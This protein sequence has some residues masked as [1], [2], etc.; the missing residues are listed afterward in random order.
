M[1]G[2]LFGISLPKVSVPNIGVPTITTDIII[3]FVLVMVLL[4][5][6]LLGHNK[7]K[8]L[9]LSVFVGLVMVLTFADGAFSMLQKANWT[10]GGKISLPVVKIVLFVLPVIA[11]EFARKEGRRG[12]KNITM[13]IILCLLT[14]AL[15]VSSV[16][17]FLDAAAL[18]DI[19][20]KSILADWIY[21]LRMVWLGAVPLVVVAE[22]LTGG[23]KSHH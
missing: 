21:G 1:P 7:L 9:A 5:G 22:S 20:D 11:L 15:L 17:S 2:I 14:G 18:K 12:G 16:F 19:M 8:T 10:V 3:A 6:L 13:T 23:K 4:Y